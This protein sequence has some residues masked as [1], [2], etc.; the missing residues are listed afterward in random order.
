MK[1]ILLLAT[2]LLTGCQYLAP[3]KLSNVQS[4]SLHPRA[5]NVYLIRGWIGVFSAGIDSIGEKLTDNGVRA[6]VYQDDQWRSLAHRIAKEYQ[7]RNSAEPLVL[8]GHSYGADD[9]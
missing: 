5:G 7:G 3:G 4:T 9:V 1:T 6:V 8:I 2:L